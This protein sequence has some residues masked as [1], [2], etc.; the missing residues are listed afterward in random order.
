LNAETIN[1]AG[2]GNLA[3]KIAAMDLGIAVAKTLP[4]PS[5]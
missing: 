2:V 1:L 3:S 5:P 4:V